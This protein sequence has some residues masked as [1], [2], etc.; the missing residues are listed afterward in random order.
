M[1]WNGNKPKQLEKLIVSS[2]LFTTIWVDSKHLNFLQ[3]KSLALC[4]KGGLNKY[5]FLSWPPHTW[6]LTMLCHCFFRCLDN[7][8]EIGTDG[9]WLCNLESRD[10]VES[11]W[12]IQCLCPMRPKYV[13]MILTI[14]G[15]WTQYFLV[16][17][18][19]PPATGFQLQKLRLATEMLDH[20]LGFHRGFYFVF[21]WGFV[22]EQHYLGKKL[23]RTFPRLI[24]IKLAS[25]VFSLSSFIHFFERFMLSIINLYSI[26]TWEAS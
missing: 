10:W 8:Q 21:F 11:L 26:L 24:C 6:L 9:S 19:I 15:S 13:F 3:E 4:F 20:L 22:G 14:P 23:L 17:W 1:D 12:W 5:S 25:P 2:T 7:R 18:S 16:S